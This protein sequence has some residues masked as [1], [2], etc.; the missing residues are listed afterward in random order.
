MPDGFLARAPRLATFRLHADH[1]A[2]L[3]DGFL[4]RAPRLATFRPS[5]SDLRTI[6][7]RVLA[8]APALETFALYAPR[9][10]AVGDD[11]LARADRLQTLTL[12]TQQPLRLGAGFLDQAPQLHTVRLGAST[13]PYAPPAAPGALAAPADFLADLPRLQTVDLRTPLRDPPPSGFLR[14]TPVRALRLRLRLAAD[15][16]GAPR[17]PAVAQAAHWRLELTCDSA[18]PAA[19]LAPLAPAPPAVLT[20]AP[21]PDAN[22][23]PAALRAFLADAP[24]ATR[25][26]LRDSDQLPPTAYAR[27][28]AALEFR[29]LAR[30]AAAPGRALLA[31]VFPL[32]DPFPGALRIFA[33]RRAAPAFLLEF[34]PYP[35]DATREPLFRLLRAP[36]APLRHLGASTSLAPLLRQWD[37]LIGAGDAA[38]PPW[39][40]P[41]L[42][43]AVPALKAPPPAQ[44]RAAARQHGLA[45]SLGAGLVTT[46]RTDVVDYFH[47][48][49]YANLYEH[50]LLLATDRTDAVDYFQQ[51]HL[52]WAAAHACPRSLLLFDR[53]WREALPPDLLDRPGSLQRV[54]IAFD[55]AQCPACQPHP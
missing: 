39:D 44:L 53:H 21:C 25:L 20:V 4:A 31:R 51:Q 14:G 54:H 3:P 18:Y 49:Y 13:S 29:R 7:D 37:A 2:A 6:G 12:R 10:A 24:P 41:C 42:Q 22:P 50:S 33:D 16:Q 28:P 32:L 40:V 23:P 38:R 35:W 55:A 27:L 36:P 30:P 9:L 8:Y 1:L 15:A 52:P 5:V 26:Q 11:F 34:D 17:L 48:D 19:W 46:D 43:L 47:G 45:L